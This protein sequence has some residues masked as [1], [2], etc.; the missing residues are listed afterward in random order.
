MRL[1]RALLSLLA[2]SYSDSPAR[3]SN[4]AIAML[5]FRSAAIACL[6]ANP[7]T[8]GSTCSVPT[9][10]TSA[11]PESLSRPTQVY[12][13]YRHGATDELLDAARWRACHPST[14]ATSQQ[15]PRRTCT[16]E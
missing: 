16:D 11:L 5:C 7:V 9:S 2:K 3:R 10:V 8:V 1:W 14:T 12:L 4:G 6:A 13:E 15:P